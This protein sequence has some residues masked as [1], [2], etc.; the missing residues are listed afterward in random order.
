MLTSNPRRPAMHTLQSNPVP[1]H[2]GTPTMPPGHRCAPPAL[3][4]LRNRPVG[5]LMVRHIRLRSGRHMLRCL[6]PRCILV[7]CFTYI[8]VCRRAATCLQNNK[9][10]SYAS[11]HHPQPPAIPY[12]PGWDPGRGTAGPCLDRRPVPIYMVNSSR[13]I[14]I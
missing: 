3:L 7:R 8:L 12:L 11:T 10:L 13:Q 2:P 6:A 9:H 5:S 1:S 4:W 14:L